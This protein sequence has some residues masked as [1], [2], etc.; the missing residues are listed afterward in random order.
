MAG[1]YRPDIDG[2]RALAISSVVLYHTGVAA[3]RGGF[4]GVDIFFANTEPRLDHRAAHRY[5]TGSRALERETK[6][7]RA[8]ALADYWGTDIR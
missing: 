3:F 5:P 8:E 2:M 6:F 7:A 4:V 1:A